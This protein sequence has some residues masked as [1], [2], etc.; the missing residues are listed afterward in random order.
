M[1]QKVWPESNSTTFLKCSRTNFTSAKE[2]GL[3]S[4]SLSLP[5]MLSSAW[6]LLRSGSKKLKHLKHQELVEA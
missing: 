6:A 2:V 1:Q 4:I 5:M 3:L